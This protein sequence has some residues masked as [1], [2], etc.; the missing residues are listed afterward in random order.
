[1]PLSFTQALPRSPPAPHLAVDSASLPLWCTAMLLT[2]PL[3]PRITCGPDAKYILG[4]H[5]RHGHA[6][7]RC[8][9]HEP[10]SSGRLQ[11]AGPTAGHE[12]RTHL[13]VLP[14]AAAPD[15]DAAIRTAGQH[16]AGVGAALGARRRTGSTYRVQHV[17]QRRLRLQS[18][19]G[20]K[21]KPLRPGRRVCIGCPQL[22]GK[23]HSPLV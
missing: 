6:L 12:R 11:G 22:G 23:A 18:L 19:S 14:V 7:R 17:T 5:A 1:M 10:M 4:W 15:V 8:P 16:V 3:C 21:T 2:P 20:E 9:G 13:E